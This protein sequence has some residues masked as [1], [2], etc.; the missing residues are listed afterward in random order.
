MRPLIRSASLTGYI[1]IA[2]AAGLDPNR[3]MRE[4]GLNPRCLVD[5]ETRVDPAAV[6]RLLETSAQAGNIQDLGLRM[7]QVRRLSNLGPVSL[8]LREQPTALLA[9]ETLVRHMRLVNESLLTR[10]ERYDD[11]VVIREEFVFD[12]HFAVRQAMELAVGVMYRTLR[13]ILGP[14]WQPRRVCF[15]HAAPRDRSSHRRFFGAMVA[16]DSD[17]NGIVCA[18]RDLAARNPS[19]DPMMARYA[20]QY[21]ESVLAG[22]D[23]AASEKVRRLIHLL[24]PTGRCRIQV[25]ANELG[26]DRRTIHRQLAREGSTFSVVLCK[27]RAEQAMR[28]VEGGDR[29]ASEIADALGFTTLSAFSR[30]FRGEFGA[31]IT[32]WRRSAAAKLGR[33]RLPH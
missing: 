18:G 3:L 14:D 4:V 9:I 13:E 26:V 22:P 5:P 16:F 31:S 8:L 30:W 25:V 28:Y 1:D 11:L 33:P 19:A 21:L 6:R 23:L 12:E 24:L 7:A 20:R 15:T 17:F 10:I 32:V 2:R 27:V 29:P